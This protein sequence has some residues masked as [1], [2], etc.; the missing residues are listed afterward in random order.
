MV[1]NHPNLP[2]PAEAIVE[3]IKSAG[4]QA[5]ALAAD[6]SKE[7]EVVAM[8]RNVVAQFGTVDILVANAGLQRD[9][10]FTK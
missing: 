10:P 8:F 5:I 6:V 1:V 4:G 3:Q 7:D 9:A 2:A